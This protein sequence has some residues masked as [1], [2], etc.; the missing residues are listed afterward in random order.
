MNSRYKE[1]LRISGD[2]VYSYDTHVATIDPAARTLTEHGKYSQTTST[3]V[4]YVAK[5]C[6][7]KIIRGEKIK[8]DGGGMLRAVSMIAAFGSVLCDN[9]EDAAAWKKRFIG[10]VD[11]IDMPEDFDSL[12]L[13]ERQRR[14]DKAISVG[15][16]SSQ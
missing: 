16:D 9:P 4:N 14:L 12:P 8:E 10:K 15:L 5:S 7:L 6:G 1:N 11:G 13:E 2:K 3:H